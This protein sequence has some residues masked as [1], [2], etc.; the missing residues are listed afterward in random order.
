VSLNATNI[1]LIEFRT[2]VE[3][4]ENELYSLFQSMDRDHNGKLDKGELKEAFRKAGLVVPNSKL[5]Q[6]FAE[7]DEN[8]DV[9]DSSRSSLSIA[10]SS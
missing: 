6:F 1:M 5:N 7:V 9:R 8:H 10:D 2:F 4:T 3:H